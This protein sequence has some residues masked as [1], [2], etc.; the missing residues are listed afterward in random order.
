M[1]TELKTALERHI[2]AR[3]AF[4]EERKA[5]REVE[6]RRDAV[7]KRMKELEREI[8]SLEG[9]LQD[10]VAT[11][12]EEEVLKRFRK[13]KDA[14]QAASMSFESIDKAI[15]GRNRNREF[16]LEA[17]RQAVNNLNREVMQEELRS[18][19]P[20]TMHILRR[21]FS[22]SSATWEDFLS[23]NL[24]LSIP[25]ER[26]DHYIANLRKEVMAS[27]GAAQ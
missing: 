16:T 3:A 13:A 26:M 8:A 27:H 14:L 20:E 7:R 18:I 2:Q 6:N 10:A 19:P 5:H 1:N 25:G 23:L 24:V 4:E 15:S 22:V 12:R 17:L 9:E 21:A 11:D